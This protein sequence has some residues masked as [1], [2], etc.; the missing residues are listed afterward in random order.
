MTGSDIE[1]LLAFE[2]ADRYG[3]M[4]RLRILEK[5]LTLELFLEEDAVGPFLGFFH[6]ITRFNGYQV[7]F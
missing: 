2:Q 1:L 6:G 7:V 5:V 4:N 3:I